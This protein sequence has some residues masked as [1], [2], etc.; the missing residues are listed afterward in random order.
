MCPSACEPD[1]SNDSWTVSMRP[2][3]SA[4]GTDFLRHPFSWN[5]RVSAFNSVA[6]STE[7]RAATHAALRATA[8]LGCS[9]I[10]TAA[11]HVTTDDAQKLGKLHAFR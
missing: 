8:A 5:A 6:F 10:A 2:T 9:G 4:G 7:P 11:R 3:I 1:Q